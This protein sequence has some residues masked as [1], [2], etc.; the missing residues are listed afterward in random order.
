[1]TPSTADH[2]PQA[3]MSV[4]EFEQLA[5]TS[6]ETVTLELINGKL[7]VKPVPDG[8]HDEIIMWVAMQCMQQQPELRLYRERGLRIGGYRSGRARPDGTLAR[9]GRFA[10]D[11]EWSSPDH[12]LMTVE[13]TS[14]DHDTDT[15]DRTEKRDGYAAASIPVYLLID[16][17]HDTLVVYSEPEKGRYRHRTTYGY[18]DTVPLPGPVDITLESEELKNY[19]G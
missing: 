19:S 16:R 11:G 7:E 18:G 3:Q 15:R 17:D 14:H 5:R 6:P 12:I 4:E 9:A 13:V 8:D 1:M 10:G 2:A